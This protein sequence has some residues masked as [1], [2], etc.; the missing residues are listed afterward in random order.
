MI[1]FDFVELLSSR[2]YHLKQGLNQVTVVFPQYP[3]GFV[4]W[5]LRFFD[6]WNHKV[7]NSE[8]KWKTQPNYQDFNIFFFD[9]D[10]GEFSLLGQF[11]SGLFI[12]T[13]INEVDGLK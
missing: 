9:A 6:L 1:L 10:F 3:L 2:I 4:S 11:L 5:N 12:P 13:I 8:K 7:R